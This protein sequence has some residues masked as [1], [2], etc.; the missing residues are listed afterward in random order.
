MIKN[1]FAL[2]LAIIV[3]VCS[4]LVLGAVLANSYYFAKK[5]IH[6]QAEEYAYTKGREIANRLGYLIK[7]I[8]QAAKNLAQTL[9]DSTLTST[10]IN[11][12]SRHVVQNNHDIFG[13]AIAFEPFGLTRD[14]LFYAIYSSDEGEEVRSH[15]I[16]NSEYRYFYMDWYQLSKE[17]TYPIWTEP[18]PAYK[19]CDTIIASYSV[20]FY[21]TDEDEKRY[22]AGVVRADISLKWLQNIVSKIK[23]YDTGY[24]AILSKNGTFIYH[25]MKELVFNETVFSLAE[26]MNDQELWDIGRKMI[27]GKTGFI[28]RYSVRDKTESFLLHMPLPVGGWSLAFLF[29]T[30]EVLKDV[31]HLALNTLLIGIGGLL[32]LIASVFYIARKIAEPIRAL[33]HS[34]LEIANGNLDGTL[35]K[36]NSNDEIGQLSKS[37]YTMQKSLQTFIR[38]LKETTIQKERIE[39]E[40][41]IAKEIQ[42]GILPKVFPPFPDCD[43]IRIYATLQSAREVGGDLYDF[44]FI[45]DRKFCF[46]IGDVSGK[47][48][49]A[50]FFM[51]ITRTLLKVIV[52]QKNDPGLALAQ[53]N[54]DLAEDNDSCMFVTLFLAILDVKT[55]ELSYGSAGH[56]PPLL[57]KQENAQYIEAINEPVAGAMTDM[58]YSTHHMKMKKGDTLFL[59]T[60][61][62]TEA[63]NHEQELFTEARLLNILDG[64]PEEHP[65][66][67]LSRVNRSLAD[68]TNGAEQ[69]DD[70][71]MLALQ[72]VGK[73][74]QE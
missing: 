49:P 39:S 40:L 17:L 67:T 68:F 6:K 56:N 24:A 53:V 34:A 74:L 14:K 7:P 18:Y 58:T 55:G 36:S 31:N 33:S 23:L 46:L 12:L 1:R 51:A 11:A 61:G 45:N 50:A 57:I 35:P 52:E 4:S 26:G 42:L 21:R 5:L 8:E 2:K 20:P 22:F 66:Q 9:E 27:D 65:E 25:P 63:M 54:D 15:Q 10:E 48:V 69:S 60:D 64:K 28:A 38:S 73:K 72:Y 13:M 71:T 62:V 43:E 70:I 3:L 16:G 37:F 19:N 44:F 30:K 59:Y 32:F 29:P 47:G 41:R